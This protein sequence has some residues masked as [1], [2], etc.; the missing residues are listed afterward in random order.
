[1]RFA[2]QLAAELGQAGFVVVS[3]FARGI[4]SAAHRGALEAGTV[5]VMAGG[6][7][8]IYPPENRDLYGQLVEAG[9]ALSE[10]PC[11]TAPLARHFPQRNRLVSGMSL[12]VVVVEAAVRSGSLITARLALDQGRELFA[13][14]GSPLDPR[15]RGANDLIRR[16]ATLVQGVEDILEVLQPQLPRRPAPLADHV[17]DGAAIDESTLAGARRRVLELVSSAPT[18][19][20]EIIRQCHLSP[21]AVLTAILELE[22]AGRLQRHPGNHVSTVC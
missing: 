7:D 3:G 15:A 8:V 2:R 16:G 10:H 5:G 9:A 19:I 1:M 21:P 18:P 6:V 17:A 4:D 20:D 14:P 12:G 11:G 22:L 13:V